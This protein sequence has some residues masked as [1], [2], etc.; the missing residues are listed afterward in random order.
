M[1][2]VDEVFGLSAGSAL[3]SLGG[4]FVGRQSEEL[5]A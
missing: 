5:A 3:G 1:Q 4:Q 2:T